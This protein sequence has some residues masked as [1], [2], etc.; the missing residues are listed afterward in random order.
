MPPR[1]EELR[2]RGH[3]GGECL[4]FLV[5]DNALSARWI[6]VCVQYGAS[7]ANTWPDLSAAF[8]PALSDRSKC[9]VRK[10]EGLDGIRC[11]QGL[12]GSADEVPKHRVSDGVRH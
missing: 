10:H 6:R 9:G 5:I 7:A 12:L 8:A 1:G 4:N 11:G 2:I 3:V